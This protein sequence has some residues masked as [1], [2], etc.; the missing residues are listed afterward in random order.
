MRR[1]LAV[2]LL[3]PLLA[4]AETISFGT[5]TNQFS[6]QFVEIGNPNKPAD[7]AGSPAPV[8]SVGYVFN[9][10]KF[11]ISVKMINSY[12]S[13]FAS[14]SAN[15]IN[16]SG[17]P[18]SVVWPGGFSQ[19]NQPAT[20]INWKEAARFVNWLNSSA[21]YQPAYRFLT[22][23]ITSDISLW[24]AGEAISGNLFRHKDAKFFLPTA[25]EWYK[26]A[27]YDPNKNGV[28]GY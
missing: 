7:L 2:V 16:A 8:G 14:T 28:G 26:G 18:S 10:A 21:G 4:E 24:G 13:Q 11:E 23:D 12:N 3:S 1:L 20:S 27:Y 22:S 19:P 17:N 6:L 25:D 9:L 5:G 15:R